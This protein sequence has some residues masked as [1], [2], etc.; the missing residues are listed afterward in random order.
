MIEDREAGRQRHC[1]SLRRGEIVGRSLQGGDAGDE[2]L[3]RLETMA[4][5][6]LI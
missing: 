1:R 2:C 3:H 6:G 4:I 5:M